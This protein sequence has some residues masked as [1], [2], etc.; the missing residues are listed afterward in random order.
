MESGELAFIVMVICATLI[1]G[2]RMKINADEYKRDSKQ[3]NE[4]LKLFD[5]NRKDE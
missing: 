1:L 5:R 4:R 2:F 3:N